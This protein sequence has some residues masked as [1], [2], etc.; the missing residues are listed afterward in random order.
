M[1]TF[2]VHKLDEHKYVILSYTR[3]LYEGKKKS[4]SYLNY[5]GIL[6]ERPWICSVCHPI[7]QNL[8]KSNERYVHTL[9]ALNPKHFTAHGILI[10]IIKI[11]DWEN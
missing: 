6:Y 8:L 4:R 11:I 3:I 7:L 1:S 2:I 10:L 9:Q 5:A